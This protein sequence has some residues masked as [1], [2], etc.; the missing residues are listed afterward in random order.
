[1][2]KISSIQ[3]ELIKCVFILKFVIIAN[4]SQKR[5]EA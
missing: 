1:M 3:G 5:K 2:Y 4:H